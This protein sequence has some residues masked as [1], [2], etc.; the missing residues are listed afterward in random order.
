MPNA[1]D[2][3]PEILKL[4][5][6]LVTELI[7]ILLAGGIASALVLCRLGCPPRS[8]WV[9][10][11]AVGP[12]L[13]GLLPV[14][15][16]FLFPVGLTRAI[17][18]VTC[19]VAGFW[20]RPKSLP[21]I[22]GEKTEPIPP[23]IPLMTLAALSVAAFLVMPWI[24]PLMAHDATEYGLLAVR[25]AEQ[26]GTAAYPITPAD[27]ETGF[28][29]PSSHPRGYAALV[30]TGID[31]NLSLP[32]TPMR[33]VTSWYLILYLAAITLLTPA[34]IPKT[35]SLLLGTSAPLFLI[36]AMDLSIDPIRISLTA[37]SMVAVLEVLKKPS[38]GL[39]ITCGIA[40][41][42]LASVHS[43]SIASIALLTLA[44]ILLSHEPLPR[45][46]RLTTIVIGTTC[47]LG[48][49]QYLANLVERGSPVSDLVEIWEIDSL[50]EKEDLRIRRGLQ[51]FPQRLQKIAQLFTTI[52]VFG[53]IWI[54]AIPGF[55]RLFR[56]RFD[57]ATLRFTLMEAA[58]GRILWRPGASLA[59]RVS[60]IFLLGYLTAMAISGVAGIDLLIKNPRYPMTTVPAATVLAAIGIFALPM[61]WRIWTSGLILTST[62]AALTIILSG[63][64][65]LPSVVAPSSNDWLAEGGNQDLTLSIAREVTRAEP[66]KTIVT[67]QGPWAR[68][69]GSSMVSHIDDRL[70]PTYL[71]KNSAETLKTL[72]ELD[73]RHIYY[74]SYFPA[75]WTNSPILDIVMSP[76]LSRAVNTDIACSGLLLE[77]LESPRPIEYL[78]L[79]P[80]TLRAKRVSPQRTGVFSR[81]KGRPLKRLTPDPDRVGYRVK[82]EFP[83]KG[84]YRFTV[85]EPW[86]NRYAWDG[87]CTNAPEQ[88]TLFLRSQFPIE[89]IELRYEAPPKSKPIKIIEIEEARLP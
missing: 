58:E 37:T 29:F 14:E 54:V 36:Q 61:P 9:I 3:I 62:M 40:F 69:V 49:W 73:V 17:L 34:G 5:P 76:G 7:L 59:G 13:L 68:W 75:C 65:A 82:V 74:S 31:P 35:I 67:S 85:A 71:G 77:V 51:S 22:V 20:P 32:D 25:L 64:L 78:P 66:H 81:V 16:S 38:L 27:P 1:L 53:L 47:L 56:V 87:V 28:F 4:E 60:V 83:N 8:G 48:G 43:S 79:G 21:T 44:I 57:P 24:S 63:S 30:A 39:S 86:G 2:A 84:F 10:G 33:V 70:I 18:L 50:G 46:A 41:G 19:G 55:F 45:R 42:G 6:P 80:E 12:I 88:F 52:S 72:E 15:L 26:G 89:S 11:F 23:S